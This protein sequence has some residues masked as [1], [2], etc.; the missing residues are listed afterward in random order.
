MNTLQKVLVGLSVVVLLVL[1]VTFPK[2]NTV[3]E[4]VV[5]QLGGSGGADSFFSRESHNG[6]AKNFYKC[7]FTTA[8]SSLCSIKA[9]AV[10][11]RLEHA[12]VRF[13]LLPA[14]A[15][16]YMLGSGT[17]NATTTSIVAVTQ[18]SYPA[19]A[20]N[21]TVSASSTSSI[22][23]PANTVINL[24]LSTSTGSTVGA[25]FTTT[26]FLTVELVEL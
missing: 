16:S 20:V 23:I 26:G 10:D 2:G 19:D 17:E 13:N 7:T 21:Q 24:Q 14:Y 12:S 8:S 18:M 4:R 25:S 11:T 3:V 5:T 6:V 15:T 9:P 22:L 1:G